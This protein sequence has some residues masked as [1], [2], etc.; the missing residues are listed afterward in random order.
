M[1]CLCFRYK[2]RKTMHVLPK[3]LLSII[4]QDHIT[5]WHWLW[6][7]LPHFLVVFRSIFTKAYTDFYHEWRY[8]DFIRP[9]VMF[10]I[11]QDNSVNDLTLC[12]QG[13]RNT[14]GRIPFTLLCSAD[15][16]LIFTNSKSPCVSHFH[17]H[18]NVSHNS[19]TLVSKYSYSPLTITKGSSLKWGQHGM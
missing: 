18:L 10:D 14:A 5:Y 8:M 17:G 9:D 11:F 4:R 1:C 7:C 3:I 16:V 19:A 2:I 6:S 12:C 13:I 15:A